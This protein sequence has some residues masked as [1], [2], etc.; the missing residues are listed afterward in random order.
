MKRFLKIGQR[1]FNCDYA[2]TDMMGYGTVMFIAGRE[3]D[4]SIYDDT[5][6]ILKM[7]NGVSEN[8]VFGSQV[9]IIDEVLSDLIG[10]TV[11]Y[12]HSVVGYAYYMPSSDENYTM[13]E[14]LYEK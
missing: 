6:I 13:G 1:V 11:C 9:Y 14:L 5:I 7:E 8:E 10:E 3:E 12:E 4:S 2:D